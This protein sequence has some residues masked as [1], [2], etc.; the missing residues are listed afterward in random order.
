ME[1]IT[2]ILSNFRPSLPL[3][4]VQRFL[5]V[6]LLVTHWIDATEVAAPPIYHKI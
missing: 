5:A 4:V 6:V 2:T 3:F 1:P